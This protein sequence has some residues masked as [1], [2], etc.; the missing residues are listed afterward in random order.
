M[1]ELLA[2]LSPARRDEARNLLSLPDRPDKVLTLIPN[3]H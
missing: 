1:S 3:Q 2:Y